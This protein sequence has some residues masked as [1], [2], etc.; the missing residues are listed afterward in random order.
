[1]KN[2]TSTN[3]LP[4]AINPNLSIR[5][6]SSLILLVLI[7]IT[8]WP[9]NAT[10]QT[11]MAHFG[12]NDN[13]IVDN[14]NVNGTPTANQNGLNYGDGW[15]VCEGSDYLYCNGSNDYLQINL[16]TTGF[17][18]IS[19]SWQQRYSTSWGTHRGRWIIQGDSNNDGIYEFQKTDNPATTSACAT[20]TVDLPASFDNQNAIRLRIVSIVTSGDYLILDDVTISGTKDIWAPCASTLIW[21]ESFSYNNFS[22]SGSG[23]PTGLTAWSTDGYD[24][25]DNGVYV[26]NSRLNGYHTTEP[27]SDR[28]QW[29]IEASDPIEIGGYSDV[30]I[31]VQLFEESDCESD[32]YVQVQYSLNGGSWTNFTTNGIIYND[33]TNAVARQ[34]GLSG[35][36][37]QLRI[38]FFNNSEDYYADDITVSGIPIVTVDDPTDLTKSGGELVS[39]IFTGTNATQFSWT[40]SNT[41]IG[42]SASGTGNISFTAADVSTPQTS[43]ITVTPSNGSCGGSPQTFTITVNPACTPPVISLHPSTTPQ[44]KCL[45]QSFT[46]LTISASGTGISYQWYSNT[47]AS[48]SGGT[49]LGSA[50]GAQTNS[51]TPQS[52]VAGTL[53]Y[54]CIVTGT[55]GTVTSNVSGAFVTNPATAITSE[56]LTG[57]T[58]CINQ[59]FSAISVTT[60]GV[61]LSYQ[62]YSNT[63]ASTSGGTS[64]GSANGAQTNTYTPQSNVAGTLYYY[65]IVT[66]TCGTVTSN[67]SGAFIVNPLA[68]A[69]AGNALTMCQGGTSTALGGTIGGSAT[70]ASWSSSVGGSFNYPSP[71]DF[72]N[73]TWTPPASFYGEAVLTLMTTGP[74]ASVT[75]DKQV[76]VH[77]L[78]PVSVSITSS[79]SGPI[80]SGSTV[81]FTS[82]AVNAGTTPAFQWKIN[83]I[84]VPGPQNQTFS[85]NTLNDHDIVTCVV[86]SSE[87]C[88]TGNPA[89]SN[90]IVMEV[91][92]NLPVSVAISATPAGP[93]CDGTSVTFTAT[94]LNGGT[95]PSYQWQLNDTNVGSNNPVYI[96]SALKQG[97]QITCI[98]TTS[99][100]CQTGSPAT[101]NTIIMVVNPILPVSVSITANPS[102]A[103]CE[104]TQ[105][106]F[107]ASPVNGGSSP[108]YQWKLNSINVGSNASTYNNASLKQGD[109]ITCVLTS[110]ETCQS[111]S[112]AT[113]NALTM[114]VNPILPASV[115]IS[116]SPAGTICS[117]TEVT[118]TA[119]PVN[120]GTTPTYQWYKG[121]TLISGATGATLVTSDLAHGDIVTVRMTSSEPCP[122]GSPATSNPITMNVTDKLPVS[123]SIAPSG[124][125][126]CAGTSV[127]FTATATNGGATPVYQWYKNSSPVGANSST[128]TT[129]PSNGDQYYVVLTSSES[130]TTGNPAT[131]PTITMNVN[132]L[133]VVSAGPDLSIPNGTST[134]ISGATATGS[135][136]L[137]YA[138]T[139]SAAFVSASLLNPTTINLSVTDQYRLTVTD[140][141]G[142]TNSDVM[143]ITITG[144]SLA[145]NP[146]AS[147][148]AV[149]AGS[150][151]QLT[152]NASGGSGT[153]TYS[154]T[155]NPAGFTSTEANP[156]VNPT[157]TTMYSLTVNDGYTSATGAVT[158]TVYPLPTVSVDSPE[159]CASVG[160]ATITATP[161][162]AGSYQY[163]W[164]VPAGAANPGNVAS[165]NASFAGNYSVVI[166][167]AN[168]CKGTGSGTLTIH[169]NPTVT[170]NSPAICA[171][172][173]PATI[174]ATPSPT[175][176][177]SYSWTVPAGM[178]DPGN[179]SSFTTDVAGEYTVEI[180]DGKSCKATSTGTLTVHPVP[181]V[182][183]SSVEI[184][185]S[186]GVASISAIPSPAGTYTYVWTVPAGVTNPGN[187]PG[188]NTAIDGTYSVTI[189]NANVCTASGSGTVTINANPTVTVNSPVICASTGSATITASPMPASGTYHYTWTVPSGASNPGD[190]ASFQASVPG[191]YTVSISDGK[192]CTASASGTLTIHANPT[193]TVN[194]PSICP[195]GST[196]EMK[197][198]PSPA[199]GSYT[200]TWVVPSGA[201]N[202]GGAASFNTNVPGNYTVTISDGNSCSASGS[203][204]LTLHAL[205]AAPVTGGDKTICANQEIPEIMVT[206]GSGETADWFDAATGGN[207]LASGSLSYK[208]TAAGTYFAQTR[209]TVTNCVSDSRTAVSL[210]I[211]PLP[212]ATIDGTAAIC[213]GGT[214]EPVITLTGNGGTGP[215]DFVYRINSGPFLNSTG[216]NQTTL[217]APSSVAGTFIYHLTSVTDHN[218]CVS[219]ITNQTAT[220]TVHSLPQPPVAVDREFCFDG[221]SHSASATPAAGE[222][223]VWYDAPVNGNVTSAPTASAVGSYSA[224]A[225]ARTDATGCESP[226]RNLVTLTIHPLPTVNAID[227]QV[228]CNTDVIA[229]IPVTGPV[230][231]TAFTWTNS[232]PGIGLQASGSG[233][234]PTFTAINTGTTPVTAT[235]AITPVANNCSGTILTFT[236]TVNPTPIADQP[237]PVTVCNDVTIPAL[238]LSGNITGASYAWTNDNTSIGLPANGTNSI[239]S[240]KA[241]NT[242]NTAA[243]ANITI[244]PSFTQ[245]GVTCTGEPKTYTITVLPT[246]TAVVPIEMTL[247]HG[248]ATTPY[249]LTGTPT[250]VS[251]NITGGSAIGLSDQTGVKEIPSFIPVAGNA[252][253][254]VTPVS[255]GCT[256]THGMFNLVVRPTPSATISGG[257][258]VCQNAPAPNLVVSN[259]TPYHVK[260]T[261]TINGT[262]SSSININGNGNASISVPTAQAGTFNYQLTEIQ[263]LDEPFCT[264]ITLTGSASVVVNALPNTTITGPLNACAGSGNYVYSTEAGMNDYVWTVSS[265]GV[266]ASGGTSTDN[267]ITI[268]WNTA[269]IQTVSVRYS[270]PQGC[271]SASPASQQVTVSSLPVPTLTGLVN[272][273]KGA[274]GITYATQAGMT[275]YTWAVSSGG[276][277]TSGGGSSNNSVTITWHTEGIQNVS[278][279][280]TNSNGCTASTPTVV[281]VTVNNLAVPTLSG[282]TEVCA[283]TSGHVYTTEAGMSNYS[284]TVSAGGSITAGN[285]STSN[286]I[287]VKWNTSGAQ[288]VSVNYANASGCAASG[289]TLYNVTVN[290]LPVPTISGDALA[291]GGSSV[292]YTTELGMSNYQW[293]V[294][295]GG[296]IVSGGTPSDPSM[297]VLWSGSGAQSVSV[298]YT[299]SNGCQSS[300]PTVKNITVSAEAQATL[301][302]VTEVCQGSTGRVYTTQ[303]GMTNYVWSI[304]AGATVTAGGTSS[305]NS[306]TITWIGSGAQ[307]ISVYYTSTNG[308][309]STTATATVNVNPLP[310]PVITGDNEVCAGDAGLLYTTESGMSNYVWTISTGGTI[311]SGGG[312]T[313]NSATV[314]WNTPGSQQISVRY[315]NA[316]GCVATASTVYPVVVHPLPLV[317]CPG[318]FKVCHNAA[319]FTLTGAAPAGGSYSGPGVNAGVFNPATA[320][321]GTHIIT[322]TYSGTCINTCTFNITVDP[323]P[324]GSNITTSVCSESELSFDLQSA[325]TNGIA[326]NFTW[327][328]TDNSNVTGESNGSGDYL[329]QSLVNNSYTIARDVTYT[330]TP[331]SEESNCPGSPFTVTVTVNP[332][333]APVNISWNSNYNQDVFE[334]CAGGS[335]LNDNDLDI[336]PTPANGAFNGQNPRWEY[337]YSTDGPW[338]PVPGNWYGGNYQFIIS[339]ELISE[340][341]DY[342]FRFARTNSYGCT[343]SSD[344]IELH[345]ISTMVVEAGGP[346]YVCSSTYQ[347]PYT[348]AGSYVG[349]ISSTP[350]TGTWTSN[351]GGTFVQNLS[352]P[353]E[354]TFTP[355]NNF[356]GEITLTLTTNDPGGECEPLTDTR[357]VR[358][359]PAGAF[360]GCQAPDT[361]PLT[362]TNANGSTTIN[363]GIELTGGD[364]SS[365]SQGSTAISHC[366]GSGTF[367]F[368][369]SFSS[370][371]NNLVWHSEDQQSGSRA[372]TRSLVVPIPTNLEI[373]DLIIITL[374]YRYG[375]VNINSPSGF[376]RIRLDNND[377]VAVATYYKIA[378]ASDL[379][380]TNYTFTSSSDLQSDSRIYSS[381]VTG[382]NPL[383]PIGNSSGNSRSLES[384]PNNWSITI[385]S[386]NY[387]SA[388]SMLVAA[389]SVAASPLYPNSPSGMTPVYYN[390]ART[391]VRVANQLLTS[392]GSTGD[393]AFTWPRYNNVNEYSFRVAAQ[394]FIIN[395]MTNPDVDAA[396]YTVNGA[397]TL[398]S[399]SDDSEGHVSI[400]VNS[401][402][403]I[404]FMVTTQ[405]NTGGPGILN[406]YNLTVPNDIPV[407]TGLTA[408]TIPDCQDPAYTPVFQP[409]TALDDCGTLTTQTTDSGVT[410][411]DCSRSQ[412]RTWVFVDNCGAASTPFV[413]TATWT[414]A[415]PFS[416]TC[417]PDPHLPPCSNSTAI[418]TAY[419]TWKAGFTHTGGCN[420][421][422]NIN[423]IPPLT[424][425]S[426]GG[427]LVFDFIATDLCGRT[428][429]CSSTFT[430]DPPSDLTLTYPTDPLLPA[431]STQAEIETAYNTWKSGF[432]FSGGCTGVTSNLASIPALPENTGCGFTLEFDF[433]AEYRTPNCV[434][435]VNHMSTFTVEAP[436][437]LKVTVPN[438]VSLSSCSTT[439]DIQTAYDTWKSGF[440][441]TGGCNPT[442][443][444]GSIPALGS[445][446]C[447]GTISFTYTADNPAGTC[448]SHA[449]ATSTFTIG[450]AS[451]ISVT[452][453]AD[454]NIPA[455]TDETT[456]ANAYNTWVNGFKA[457]GG[458]QVTT[459]IADVPPLGDITCGG[460]LSFTFRAANGP[461]RCAGQEECTATFTV[462]HTS[463]L[464]VNAPP[465]ESVTG[466][467]ND[468]AVMTA[469]NTWLSQF[470]HSG[471]CQTTATD[472]T[473]YKLP[474]LCSGTI[475][476]TYTVSDRCGQSKSATSSFTVT[477][478]A[479]TAICPGNYTVDGCKTQ[480]E[481]NAE[482]STWLAGFSYTGGC[483]VTATNLSG[484]TPPDALGDTIYVEYN[485]SDACGQVDHCAASFI[486]PYCALHFRTV[487]SG[488]WKTPSIWITSPDENAWSTTNKTPDWKNSKSIR[489]MDGH[490]ITVSDFIPV[491]RTIINPGGAVTIDLSGG[492]LRNVVETADGHTEFII[493]SSPDPTSGGNGSGSLIALGDFL[494]KLT[495]NRQ[496]RPDDYHY[497]SSP[498][499]GLK[500]SD[501][502]ALNSGKVDGIWS[503]S[504]PAQDWNDLTSSS[505]P[506]QSGKGYNL[507]YQGGDGKYAFPGTVV[508]SASV[509]VSSPFITGATAG[510]D[511][512]AYDNLELVSGRDYGAGGWNLLGNPF[513]SAMD[514]NTFITKNAATL[515]FDP[516]YQ[517]IYLYAGDEGTEGIYYWIGVDGGD[518]T[519]SQN[520]STNIQAGQGFFVLAR[521]NAVSFTFDNSMQLHDTDVKLKSTRQPSWPGLRLTAQSGGQSMSTIVIFNDDMSTGLDPGYDIGLL[522]SGRN[523]EI[524]TAL[525]KDNGFEFARQ[526]LPLAGY[527]NNIIPVGVDAPNG[528]TV[529]FSAY[530]VPIEN[531]TF[532]LEDRTAGLITDLGRENYTVAL[533]KNTLGTGRF[534]I[535]ASPL[536]STERVI[537]RNDLTVRIWT[538]NQKV[539][540][541]G[542]VSA[543]AKASVY[544]MLGRKIY[545]SRLQD[546]R[547]NT[548]ELPSVVK[549]V[550][551]VRV[552]DG[553]RTTTRKVVF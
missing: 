28:T 135:G 226:S 417:P 404:G 212:T 142:C 179:V 105:V 348:L 260:V 209:N 121:A 79:P 326:C 218:N 400:P 7:V 543:K 44:T 170:V 358:V 149:C 342:Y 12:L 177:Y 367:S 343:S 41:A 545:E 509:L 531:G 422:T 339:T 36:T 282:P 383:S 292:I 322:Y 552:D 396:Y 118:F 305:S 489:V 138:W 424:D 526:A 300:S 81:N 97:D 194:S 414:V 310:V 131:S 398:L 191:I 89:T 340:I 440:F 375:Q 181:T 266:I 307:A 146:V 262:V 268:T 286:S 240:F 261:Y 423:E 62:W 511:R 533:P 298:G 550:Y 289:A 211:H 45:N 392:S 70:D 553:A 251:F 490:T 60:N 235:I 82:T 24:W 320:G 461:D 341:G 546:E 133:P 48:T 344:I 356:V 362:N 505:D 532:W 267:T 8:I 122:S 544:D 175:G 369:W 19:V 394:M 47:S 248:I 204:N 258:T 438:D 427:Q 108:V 23:T 88:T 514:A 73:A 306:V 17:S 10:S 238:T 416:V 290:A 539:Y 130:C 9:E 80:C 241:I 20:V 378:E 360:Q 196:A 13:L 459:N 541:E 528:G 430:V 6:R 419:N 345:V 465:S 153:Y 379:S 46:S 243:Q 495:Y 478:A 551:M 385:P 389:V 215:Y 171:G 330:V 50:N 506:F 219:S 224:Y 484:L 469:F 460:Q 456:I 516:N 4:K 274:T 148:T 275:N 259:P 493:E 229:E 426:C 31:E 319:P 407:A 58:V 173:G 247:C 432:S 90:Q 93:V 508:R 207:L 279:N 86:T 276:T 442:T 273:C 72:A 257:T 517:A 391:A 129:K 534:F 75:A 91:N 65:C 27:Y 540:I 406:I 519:D 30:E 141:N 147:P 549:G 311:T 69:D 483:N 14:D 125:T 98:V 346:D 446:A 436:V 57:Q 334:V 500:I 472:L 474:D 159:I 107:T 38:I 234:I 195:D 402:D 227:N 155:S 293:T 180:T 291:C 349:G 473:G 401:K 408:I 431:C 457:T 35:S 64:L 504:E 68:T 84:D 347:T 151:S 494:G 169:P 277:I 537:L 216:N 524:Y 448:T 492:A 34:T 294:S 244:T 242:G 278:V 502:F 109:V 437:E 154:W 353:S 55:C 529:T 114:Q 357:I 420:V 281:N 271:A 470:S 449:E 263:Y 92:P 324:V 132:A 481:I 403:N 255:N 112:P 158:I 283:G 217:T 5:L 318:D 453:P 510:I 325:I 503:W 455:C 172:S 429:T 380:V 439:S 25:D 518:W 111:G 496:M 501:F 145:V 223:V 287:T 487:T 246:P 128:Y 220:I 52:N 143:T 113:S 467:A 297:T 160:S 231:E 186:E 150:P 368:D 441:A 387:T 486:T 18:T 183:V 140:V 11:T 206:V 233:N 83:G 106:T 66:G 497:F 165:F 101:S 76:T 479:L 333:L 152:A 96:N 232:H 174:S 507:G 409:P 21:S 302:G 203:G 530:M 312:T 304:P 351:N 352:N 22:T 269:G 363:C 303:T 418:E 454:P 256:G 192:N 123:V 462:G 337:S 485:I 377:Y 413:Q 527:E 336:I 327:T 187:V 314:T 491:D 316:S 230:S 63:N 37:L 15:P 331:I 237:A 381:R 115:T 444:I 228:V 547:Y 1:M 110:S 313:D 162:S 117:G 463:T 525:V 359:L 374:H 61:G 156:T 451:P 480:T 435:S 468:P 317:S 471:G 280:F 185:A 178:T 393:R 39:V 95:S 53:Y 445:I 26:Y 199:S 521:N 120:G 87:T 225:A 144:P 103:I 126:I 59:P 482:F 372:T 210:T 315:T 335:V 3:I 373:G 350:K 40:N 198:T 32:D 245:G 208:P 477:P 77:R 538:S 395:P 329:V 67:V 201:T 488:N 458:C 443:N 475:N 161:G 284:W 288:T 412:S 16:S 166:T 390:N 100:T 498:V 522:S 42:L 137:T 200:Y 370:P 366:S 205:P 542:E 447:G 425:L 354:A 272:V 167:D 535:H 365:G 421:T 136:T 253:I 51:Y 43:T 386:V 189:T 197:A 264:N 361:W 168:L 85:S 321:T 29:Y 214:P 236:I 134:P 338:I 382:H 94:P 323:A 221:A 104:G 405:R 182:T 254:T 184:C 452:C 99:E 450:Q 102:G 464:T 163:T 536:T 250:D 428:R 193:V 119:T 364:N 328:Y 239:P 299:N 548:F 434:F 295:A 249:P 74:C 188:F 190:V 397:Q 176:T 308:C 466:C 433:T 270:T 56:S 301:T 332:V 213:Q 415:L 157:V 309:R 296:A 222:S 411:N 285:N 202:P 410:E 54:Y 384:I 520:S 116:A 476:V 252:L 399:N 127:T 515:S 124:N 2:Y 49:S 71:G 33:F 376:T 371:T 388:N 523:V 139:P 164:S 265:G 355:P 499:G 513:T 78:L 512:P